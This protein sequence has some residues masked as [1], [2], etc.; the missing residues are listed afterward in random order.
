MAQ[1]TIIHL[2]GVHVVVVRGWINLRQIQD[3]PR[4][5]YVS[6]LLIQSRGERVNP[7]CQWCE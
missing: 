2:P 3:P 7:A 1:H 4:S 5:R 6:A